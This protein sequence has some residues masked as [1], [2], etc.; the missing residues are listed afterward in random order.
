MLVVQLV[1]EF[2]SEL[3]QHNRCSRGHLQRSAVF[4]GGCFGL[5][6]VF[7][8]HCGF[9]FR[10]KQIA[11]KKRQWHVEH[12][13]QQP[14]WI[15]QLCPSGEHLDFTGFG[16]T[17]TRGTSFRGRGT[18]FGFW[19][20]E[21]TECVLFFLMVPFMN[22]GT[23]YKHTEKRFMPLVE[24]K[25]RSATYQHTNPLSFILSPPGEQ[26]SHSSIVPKPC[27]NNISTVWLG[28][29]AAEPL[30]VQSH[31]LHVFPHPCV[32]SGTAGTHMQRIKIKGKEPKGK[33]KISFSRWR[34]LVILL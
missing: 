33:V 3:L 34:Q 1:C 25:Y 8:S 6:C 4:V 2:K 7:L 23:T 32:C 12:G 18:I 5:C 16:A 22:K 11:L 27:W 24:W 19:K 13:S 10:Q 31:L 29:K 20:M 30:H 28:Q 9:V 21:I 15:W 14:D 26:G 17:L